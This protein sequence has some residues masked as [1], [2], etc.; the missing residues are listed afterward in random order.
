MEHALHNICESAIV[1]PGQ[2]DAA[3]L[4]H[5]VFGE[6]QLLQDPHTVEPVRLENIVQ[7]FDS[8]F[9]F[10]IATAVRNGQKKSPELF[11]RQ[12]PFLQE[13]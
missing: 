7:C 1:L 8:F 12:V 6:Y 4:Y 9:V 2:S 10:K 11:W 5:W 3:V 13:K